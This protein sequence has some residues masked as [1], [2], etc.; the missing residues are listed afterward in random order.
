MSFLVDLLRQIGLGGSAVAAATCLLF[1]FYA[2]RAKSVAGRAASAGAAAVAYS[3][4]VALVLG[5]GLA[6]GWFDPNVGVI[7]EHLRT[8]ATEFVERAT[9]PGRRLLR[10]L[11]ETAS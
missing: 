3:I 6:L 8:G 11:V 5:F 9:G 4:V 1:A 2:F 10:W 7:V